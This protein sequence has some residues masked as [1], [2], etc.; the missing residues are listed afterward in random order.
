MDVEDDIGLSLDML[1]ADRLREWA[2]LLLVHGGDISH[3]ASVPHVAG[4]MQIM[5]TNIEKAVRDIGELRAARR[6]GEARPTGRGKADGEVSGVC[7]DAGLGAE[8]VRGGVDAHVTAERFKI[9]SDQLD[10]LARDLRFAR[11]DYRDAHEY[12]AAERF[13]RFADEAFQLSKLAAHSMNDTLEVREVR[14]TPYVPEGWL[15]GEIELTAFV[16]A[17]EGCD[18]RAVLRGFAT[19]VQQN[20]GLAG[21][22]SDATGWQPIE[23]APKDG[24][25]VLAWG[26]KFAE[27]H[28]CFWTTWYVDRQPIDCWGNDEEYL[29]NEMAP[30]HWMPLPSPPG[31]TGGPT[32]TDRDPRRRRTE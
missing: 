6:S 7:G 14:P 29:L 15:E 4:K 3:W 30:T 2:R 23:T 16:L 13:D 10:E 9:L 22:R 18:V 26:P 27:P 20:S 1:D 25:H 17:H 8:G 12:E 31:A 28:F 32:E 24:A 11:N 5:A 19:L 21:S